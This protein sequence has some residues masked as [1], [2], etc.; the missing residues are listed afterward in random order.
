MLRSYFFQENHLRWPEL[1]DQF[2]RPAAG[3]SISNLLRLSCLSA[4][5]KALAIY[6]KEFHWILKRFGDI[7]GLRCAWDQTIAACIPAGPPPLALCLLPWN[8]EDNASTSASTIKL[9]GVPIA[10]TISLEWLESFMLLKL[11]TRFLKLKARFLT[12]AARVTVTNGL[13][14]GCVWYLLIM[15]AGKDTFL[16]KLQRLVDWYVWAGR[17]RVANV[18]VPGKIRWGPHQYCRSVQGT[19]WNAGAFGSFTLFSSAEMYSPR[20]HPSGF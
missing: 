17:S 9:L 20:T 1:G 3:W 12:L 14:L 10:Q 13:I 18:G 15:W 6:I 4:V 11:E 7:S 8:W 16:S 2:W 5:I 19:N